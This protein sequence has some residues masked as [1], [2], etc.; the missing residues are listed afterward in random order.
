M[1]AEEKEINEN[2]LDDRKKNKNHIET[3]PIGFTVCIRVRP[4]LAK[5]KYISEFECVRCLDE[6]LIV[7]LDPQYEMSPEDVFRQNRNREKQ[8]AFDHVFDQRSSQ[9]IFCNIRLYLFLSQI[10]TTMLLSHLFLASLKVIIL[11]YLHMVPQVLER[12]TL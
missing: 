7:L 3:S 8:Y 12:L 11:Q 4:L 2:S 9:V 1:L 6:K 10:S 5:D